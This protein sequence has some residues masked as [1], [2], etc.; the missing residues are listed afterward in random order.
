MTSSQHLSA[1][2]EWPGQDK[3]LNLRFIT[4]GR[5]FLRFCASLFLPLFLQ[6]WDSNH[7]CIY[8]THSLNI[9][10]ADGKR[11]LGFNELSTIFCSTN[12]FPAACLGI[13]FL[14]AWST[15]QASRNLEKEVSP[16]LG[17]TVSAQSHSQDIKCKQL[18]RSIQRISTGFGLQLNRLDRRRLSVMSFSALT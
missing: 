18:L 1:V 13:C 5:T 11:M 12:K 9:P 6:Q 2:Y 14:L 4:F 15:D 16:I 7:S 17:R 8:W 3:Q 10:S